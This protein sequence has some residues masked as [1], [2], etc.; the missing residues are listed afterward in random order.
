MTNH[1][2]VTR[3][4]AIADPQRAERLAKKKQG[5]VKDGHH[6]STESCERAFRAAIDNAVQ[7][8]SLLGFFEHENRDAW[9]P[10]RLIRRRLAVAATEEDELVFLDA[11]LVRLIDSVVS[12]LDAVKVRIREAGPA[13]QNPQRPAAYDPAVFFRRGK[14]VAVLMPLAF[15]QEDIPIDVG[16][17]REQ[18]G[19]AASAGDADGRSATPQQEALINA[20][21]G[22]GNDVPWMP[23][24]IAALRPGELHRLSGR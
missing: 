24:R 3:K 4:D 1:Y 19:S 22:F 21:I 9:K 12:G 2:M 5:F 20:W 17:A 11:D 14:P 15:N 18:I 7:P 23:P 13:A 16:R 8:A 10:E 6:L